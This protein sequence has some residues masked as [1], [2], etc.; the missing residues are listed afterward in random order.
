MSLANR[1]DTTISVLIESLV[2]KTKSILRRRILIDVTLSQTFGC[3]TVLHIEP[4]I[5]CSS[6]HKSVKCDYPQPFRSDQKASFIQKQAISTAGGP[7][8]YYICGLLQQF[9]FENGIYQPISLTMFRQAPHPSI[10]SMSAQECGNG[11]RSRAYEM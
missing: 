6:V 4:S 2:T 8:E 3:S 10:L 1:K 7:D 9:P 5:G 11:R